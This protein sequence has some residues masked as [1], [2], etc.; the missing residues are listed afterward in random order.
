M[1]DENARFVVLVVLVKCPEADR[2]H[3][4]TVSDC[5]ILF[6]DRHTLMPKSPDTAIFVLTDKLTDT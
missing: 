2:I 3:F 5:L 6:N 4:I 1:V